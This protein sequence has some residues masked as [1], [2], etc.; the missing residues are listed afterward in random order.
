MIET[1]LQEKYELYSFYFVGNDEAETPPGPGVVSLDR[2][3][4]YV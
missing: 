3:R 2:R 4:R 1:I